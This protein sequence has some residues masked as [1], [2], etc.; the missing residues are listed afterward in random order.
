[1]N[2]KIIMKQNCSWNHNKKVEVNKNNTFF[3]II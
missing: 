1:M 3:L 2:N